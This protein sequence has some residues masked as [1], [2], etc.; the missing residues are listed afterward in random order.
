M[1]PFN[2]FRL[3]KRLTDA[4]KRVL[5]NEHTDCFCASAYTSALCASAWARNGDSLFAAAPC[6]I[7]HYNSAWFLAAI[8]TTFLRFNPI[9]RYT[10]CLCLYK[11]P[12]V[13]PHQ[14]FLGAP[15]IDR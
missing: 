9:G 6:T 7:L 15:S 5:F 10:V 2:V 12:G 13:I 3:Q 4:V 8:D 11:G 14:S 1:P